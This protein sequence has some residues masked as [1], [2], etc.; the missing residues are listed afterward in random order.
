MSESVTVPVYVLSFLL[1]LYVSSGETVAHSTFLRAKIQW[2][3]SQWQEMWRSDL[4]KCV[5]LFFFL[6]FFFR[7]ISLATPRQLF[8]SSNMTQRWQR[9]EI[10][11][12]EYLMFLN[13]I[14]GQSLLHSSSDVDPEMDREG[15]FSTMWLWLSEVHGV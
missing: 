1:V 15:L 7:R 14:A 11:N 2:S 10:S 4:Q 3:Q 13:T 12:F 8:K 6:F 9:R 5:T